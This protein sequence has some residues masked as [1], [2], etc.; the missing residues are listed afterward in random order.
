VVQRDAPAPEGRGV[1]DGAGDILLGVAGGLG[2]IASERETGRDRRC[3]RAAGAM[4]RRRV[5]AIDL[6]FVPLVIVKEHISD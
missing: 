1:P 2:E 3:V 5:H 6:E 4:Q